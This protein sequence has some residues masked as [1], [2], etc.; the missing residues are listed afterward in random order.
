MR[1]LRPAPPGSFRLCSILESGPSGDLCSICKSD[2]PFST[3]YWHVTLRS[4]ILTFFLVWR[5]FTLPSICWQCGSFK[6]G[7]RILTLLPALRPRAIVVRGV[8]RGAFGEQKLCS[9]DA[10]PARRRVERRHASGSFPG[11]DSQT[12][13]SPGRRK[14]WECW[15]LYPFNRQ[16]NNEY[17]WLKAKYIY[18][19]IEQ[20]SRHLFYNINPFSTHY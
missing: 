4:L 3:H 17:F 7:D 8:H 9:L 15:A 11:R 16:A 19:H 12:A 5:L 2:H 13:N 1:D 6:P 10:A 14:L 18:K 20:V